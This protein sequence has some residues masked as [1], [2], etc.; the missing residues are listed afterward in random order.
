LWLKIREDDVKRN[1]E[2]GAIP[3]PS[4]YI[5][6]DYPGYTICRLSRTNSDYAKIFKTCVCTAKDT[7]VSTTTNTLTNV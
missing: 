5:V 4:R 2:R 6:K 7:G 1:H 3:D